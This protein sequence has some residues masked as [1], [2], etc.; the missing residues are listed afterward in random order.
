MP[1]PAASAV[2]TLS[3]HN[4]V[5]AN[6]RPIHF[7]KEVPQSRVCSLC[8]TVPSRT[9]QLPCSH[10]LCDSCND[11]RDQDGRCMCPLDLE[12]FDEGEC[13]WNDFPASRASSLK[14]HCWN[15]CNGCEFV[16]T[17]EA[18]LLHYER[19]CD[20]HA[21]QCP[22]CERRVKR[23]ELASHYVAGCSR[24][25]PCSRPAQNCER[26]DSLA[27]RDLS[28]TMDAMTS[29]PKGPCHQ[30]LSLVRRRMDE[31]VQLFRNC[32]AV[33]L[34]EIGDVV[35]SSEENLVHK[36]EEFK[37]SICCTVAQLNTG[38]KELKVLLRDPCSDH[39]PNLQ[40]Q[41]NE[42]VEQSKANYA[43]L[44]REMTAALRDSESNLGVK[45][46]ALQ[47]HLSSTLAL[48][49]PPP[50]RVLDCFEQKKLS[51]ESE[52]AVAATS[53]GK[54]NIPWQSEKKLILRKLD[55]FASASL[56]TLEFMRQECLSRGGR[57]WIS[58]VCYTSGA[59]IVT[60]RNADK[61]LSLNAG[62]F[63]EWI[64]RHRSGIFFHIVFAKAAIGRIA[65][66]VRGH[67][68]ADTPWYS[69]D[70]VA[71]TVLNEN[72]CNDNCIDWFRDAFSESDAS[73]NDVVFY[74]E[75]RTLGAE[76]FIQGGELKFRLQL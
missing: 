55:A 20:L 51:S 22:R 2:L 75:A 40:G 12:P 36:M 58:E 64:L 41:M 71:L 38:L 13:L 43:T 39:L 52:G 14:A 5:G 72:Q 69:W 59:Y 27:V 15:E 3:G 68:F 34:S 53:S 11:A 4:V 45:I 57:P 46:D 16:G 32:E 37:S 35:V 33:R 24:G 67:L 65:V 28:E 8:R 50:R 44:V 76:G 30:Q 63:A 56:C 17:I 18:V 23:T 19:E 25:D 31:L 6:W 7:T 73:T 48:K 47:A 29:I 26:G 70:N 54:T 42:V 49:L 1:D 60:L 21:L 66:N 10:F 62:V 61:I 9:V 74:V